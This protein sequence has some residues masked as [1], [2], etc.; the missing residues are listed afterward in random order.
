MT[1]LSRSSCGGVRESVF[2]NFLLSC[3][4]SRHF[5]FSNWRESHAFKFG[6][7]EVP[8]HEPPAI[9][10]AALK[11]SFTCIAQSYSK[12]P[13]THQRNDVVRYILRIRKPSLIF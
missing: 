9:A 10:K 8:S 12:K 2:V 4:M 1:S 13:P 5:S 6:S 7:T 11:Y 3:S